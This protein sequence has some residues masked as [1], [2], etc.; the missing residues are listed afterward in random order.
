MFLNIS[1]LN[2][3][4]RGGSSMGAAGS[5]GPT[6]GVKTMRALMKHSLNL[7]TIHRYEENYM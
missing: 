1:T 4:I 2:R 3:I 6:T 5:R 7:F